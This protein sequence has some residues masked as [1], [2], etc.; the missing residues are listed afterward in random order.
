MP[1]PTFAKT[2]NLIAFLE[3]PS[4]SNGFE[5][6]VD[7]LNANQIKYALTVSPTIY[8]A[9]I[10][11]F[12]T[13]LKIKTVNDDVRLQAL[14]DEK[15]IVIIEASIRHDLKLNDAE[16]I[17]VNPSL[18]KKVFANIK[19]VGTG[20]SGAV[21][22]LFRIM[23]VQVVE[24]VGV[25]P[26]AIQ[27]TPIPDA[28]S[29]SLPQRPHKPRRKTAIV[30]FYLSTIGGKLNATNEE[31]VS[32]API[33]IITAQPS[34]STKITVDITTTPK[35]KGIV[36]HDMKES[37]T[38]TTF[39]KSHVKDRGK[40]KLVKEPEIQKSKV[41]KSSDLLFERQSDAVR[42]YQALKRK[43]VSVAQARKNMMIYLKNMAGYKMEFL[44]ERA[45]KRLDLYLKKNT[46]KFKP[47]L[48][49]AREQQEAEELKR[50][51]EI[52][53]DD[54]DDVFVNVTTLSSK[55][56]TIVEYKIYKEGKKEHFQIIR[57]NSNHQMYLTF[58]TMLKNFN[59]EDLEVLWKIFKDRFRE[60]QLKEVLDVF[61]WHALKVMFKHTIEDSVWKLQK[62]PKGLARVKNWKLFDYE[63][64]MAYDLLS[65]NDSPG[66]D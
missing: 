59:I 5:Q 34:Q 17:Y 4:E 26:T 61:L 63:V 23:M 1:T 14:I 32:A 30:E 48:K 24:E 3:K 41:K 2:H 29:T 13:T 35:A 54:E 62:G 33:N 58:S 36:F 42:K 28:P 56:L 31:L 25:L 44:R 27:D 64:E 8:T 39:S 20:F 45:M 51:L 57:A 60:S 53:P 52:V 15:K 6:I 46:T 43:P 40:D 18:T 49:K 22:S 12:C 11:Q 21:T 50:N 38:R 37:T 65:L 19:R 7:F 55:P 10:K 47:C 9:R 16:G 66:D